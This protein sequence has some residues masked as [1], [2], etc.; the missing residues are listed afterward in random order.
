MKRLLWRW[1]V[2]HHLVRPRTNYGGL[3]RATTTASHAHTVTWWGHASMATRAGV[4]WLSL[5]VLAG[6]LYGYWRHPV[7][8][9]VILAICLVTG[10]ATLALRLAK[11]WR[12]WRHTRQ[13]VHPLATALAPMLELSVQETHQAIHL[14]TTYSTIVDG[15]IGHISLPDAYPASPEQRK[16]VEHLI[17]SRLPVEIETT[18]QTTR[19]PMRL[20]LTA[21]PPPPDKVPWASM[22]PA[23]DEC[24]K[25]EVVIGLDKK[26]QIYRGSFNC[27]DPHWGM[28]VGSGRGK[29]TFLQ[30]TAAQI[31]HQDPNASATIIDPKITSLDA[32]A[33]IPGVTIANNP[34]DVEGMWAAIDDYVREME[35]RL[36]VLS[37]D[38]TAEFPIAL[39]IIDELNQ[40]SAMTSAVWKEKKEKGDPSTAPIWMRIASVLWMGRV[41]RCH[42]ILVGQ[43][44]DER[45]TGG[46]GLRDSLGFRGLGGFRP[47]T[48]M[49]LIGT[50]PIP[51]SQKQRG[52][53][54][55]SDGQEETW[56]QNIYGTP[57]EIRDYALSGR[58]PE[59][60]TVPDQRAL[61]PVEDP[62]QGTGTPA[63]EA[64]RWIVGLAAAADYLGITVD[65]LKKRRQRDPNR[66]PAEHRH[67]NQPAWLSTS[68]DGYLS[69]T[70]TEPEKV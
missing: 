48:W 8:T 10:L 18:W 31:L 23:L 61:F 41:A 15:P 7:A 54:I 62:P 6:G 57:Q 19:R 67:G 9:L 43:R 34:R 5:A 24:P 42:C 70:V 33:G 55:Y 59:L 45:A 58:R 50:T 17:R 3:R 60:S 29:S 20:Q 52:R 22:L 53:W 51:R 37:E 30:V 39:L 16:T 13:V 25:G 63:L 32:L 36:N 26:R 69:Q 49:M 14:P 12:R 1:A 46:I 44:L 21:S 66:F 38:P 68:L 64:G 28:S 40:F 35:R 4:R 65:A 47:Q 56:I 2:G 11:I 27:D